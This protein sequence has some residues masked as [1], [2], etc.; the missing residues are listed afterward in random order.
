[1]PPLIPGAVLA[2][3]EKEVNKT[4]VSTFSL[5]VIAW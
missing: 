2:P 3:E 5:D 4:D 1:M